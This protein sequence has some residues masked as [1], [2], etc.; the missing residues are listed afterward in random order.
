MVAV[1][2]C[3]EV[4]IG[5]GIVC[6]YVLRLI[7]LVWICLNSLSV[8]TFLVDS[9]MFGLFAVC[10]YVVCCLRCFGVLGGVL[11]IALFVLRRGWCVRCCCGLMVVY[12]CLF[13]YWV[14]ICCCFRYACWMGLLFT[15]LV[16]MLVVVFRFV[17]VLGCFG[18]LLAVWFWL[19]L[20]VG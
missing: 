5:G 4:G 20:F 18:L 16:F 9:L 3:C 12:G 1:L 19:L 8:C 14:W 11:A 13:G 2:L 7:V 15:G 10:C 6:C 17:C